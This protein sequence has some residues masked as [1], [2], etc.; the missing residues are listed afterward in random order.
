MNDDT[1]CDVLAD[2]G[3]YDA[4]ADLVSPESQHSVGNMD[5]CNINLWDSVFC[6][7]AWRTAAPNF[8]VAD[9]P[10]VR[11]YGSEGGHGYGWWKRQH[12]FSPMPDSGGVLGGAVADLSGSANLAA[13]ASGVGSGVGPGLTEHVAENLNVSGILVDLGCY[14]IKDYD[15]PSETVGV[16]GTQDLTARDTFPQVS[17]GLPDY[18]NCSYESVPPSNG[19]DM[20]VMSTDSSGE[21]WLPDFCDTLESSDSDFDVDNLDDS[22]PPAP[23]LERWCMSSESFTPVLMDTAQLAKF[24]RKESWNSASVDYFVRSR[25]NFTGPE[26]GLKSPTPRGIP[27]PHSVFDMYWTD[28][29]LDRIVLETR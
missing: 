1:I 28:A 27:Q 16:D 6:D 26:P 21:E 19:L 14:P 13:A 7:D 2:V 29:I 25:D 23:G 22:E 18:M 15:T 8:R 24:Y 4:L 20:G 3:G 11:A 9:G 12:C 10:Q 17:L 5:T